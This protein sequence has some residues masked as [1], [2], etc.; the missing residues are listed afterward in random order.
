MPRFQALDPECFILAQ[1]PGRGTS[2][3]PE[4]PAPGPEARVP[5]KGALCEFQRW[6]GLIGAADVENPGRVRLSPERERLLDQGAV[7]RRWPA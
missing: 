7:D 2:C 1:M 5:V 6:A 4:S 3:R